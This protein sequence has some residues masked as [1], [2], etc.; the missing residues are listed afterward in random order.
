MTQAD[1]KMF[2]ELV[3]AVDETTCGKPRS[4]NAMK[5]MFSALMPFDLEQV[6]KALMQFAVSQK[7]NVMAKPADIISALTGDSSERS[8]IAWREFLRVVQIY[9]YYDSVRFSHPA[10]HYVVEQLG[11]WERV[12]QEYMRMSE[13]DLHFREKGFRELFELGLKH[14][15]WDNVRPYLAGFYENDN[16]SKGLTEYAPP[17]IEAST[18]QKLDRLALMD[19]VTSKA[20]LPSVTLSP[21][22]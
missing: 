6:R 1:W 13:S 22:S 5:I 21:I 14:A 18:G 16:R 15:T 17:I 7:L 19:R 9:G 3:Q 20:E 10:F 12:S 8:A 11:G 2:M 4:E